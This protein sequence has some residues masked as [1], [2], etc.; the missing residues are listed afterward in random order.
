MLSSR[1]AL[2]VLEGA[3][4]V[5]KSTQVAILADK[6]REVGT[7]VVM[8]R[9]PG[10]TDTGDGIRSLLLDPSLDVSPEAEALL[11]MASR[12]QLVHQVIKPAIARGAVVLADR[13][14]LSTYAY[15]VHGRGLDEQSIRSLNGFAVAG[16]VPALTVLLDLPDGEGMARAAAR[17]PI[18]RIEDADAQF[19]ARVA[20]AFRAFSAPAWQKNHPECGPIVKVDASGS[21]EEVAARIWQAFLSVGIETFQATSGSQ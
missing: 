2:V 1:G 3:E 6:L 19:H 17:G 12:A 14:F 16:V 21:K 13:F 18:D 15:Q 10:G 11:F 9:E 8:V 5:G 20:A 7:N 4:G